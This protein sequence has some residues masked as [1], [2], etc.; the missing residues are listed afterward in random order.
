MTDTR[1]M[2]ISMVD[3]LSIWRMSS[4]KVDAPSIFAEVALATCCCLNCGAQ[5][6]VDNGECDPCR[7]YRD[8]NGCQ[9]PSKLI[10]RAAARYEVKV[11]G[12]TKI[13]DFGGLDTDGGEYT[14]RNFTQITLS[15]PAMCS[16]ECGRLA[17]PLDSQQR[18]KTCADLAW[19]RSQRTTTA[20]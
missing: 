8:R 17:N 14:T 10:K 15:Q 5:P 11:S 13:S 3:F 16:S 18:C 12:R 4:R 1:N 19:Y 2:D 6:V 9:R 7:K 20:A